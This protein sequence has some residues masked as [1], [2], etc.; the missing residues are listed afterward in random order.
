M[1]YFLQT[2]LRNISPKIL[3]VLWLYRK[4]SQCSGFPSKGD[5]GVEHPR[6]ALKRGSVQSSWLVS[7]CCLVEADSRSVSAEPVLQQNFSTAHIPLS[8]SAAAQAEHEIICFAAQEEVFAMQ[9]V[10]SRN[11][12]GVPRVAKL[13]RTREQGCFLRDSSST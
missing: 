5:L 9:E 1:S 3:Q 12:Y 11:K 4:G 7:V 10:S 13:A 2:P 6:F 8:F